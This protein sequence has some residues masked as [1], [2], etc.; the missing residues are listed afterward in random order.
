MPN[1]RIY[2]S[3]VYIDH[4]H[5]RSKSKRRALS[6]QC[7]ERFASEALK[8]GKIVTIGG[9]KAFLMLHS[10]LVGLIATA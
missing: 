9:L 6:V 7:V 2:N 5:W 3:D 8:E 1:A 10:I 4:A